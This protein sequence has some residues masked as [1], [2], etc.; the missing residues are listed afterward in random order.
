METAAQIFK[1]K[2][3]DKDTKSLSKLK[4]LQDNNSATTKMSMRKLKRKVS[5]EFGEHSDTSPVGSL[6]P[7]SYCV[8]EAVLITL[9][10]SCVYPTSRVT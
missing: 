5:H 6:V 1:E 7:V 9:F 4:D 2:N 8:Y 3:T 10:L